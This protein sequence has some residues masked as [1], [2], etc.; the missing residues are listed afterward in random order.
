MI[1]AVGSPLFILICLLGNF[2]FFVREKHN[3][4]LYDYNFIIIIIII[5]VVVIIIMDN[6]TL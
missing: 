2:R 1:V 4:T 5:V 3:T 6:R